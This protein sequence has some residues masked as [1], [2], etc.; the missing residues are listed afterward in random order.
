MIHD[1]TTDMEDPPQFGIL[2]SMRTADENSLEYAGEEVAS[3]QRDFYP[4]V[5]AL[6]TRLTQQTAF[7]NA[8]ETARKLG[9]EM[10]VE[11]ESSGIIEAYETSKIFGF[12]D[13]V[14]IRVKSTPEG[15]RVD[16][17]SVSRVGM[18]D[19][20]MNAARINKFCEMFLSKS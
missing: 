15:S 19:L 17:R 18:S 4:E 11:D 10:V 9:W 13:D 16:L 8:A 1:I 20:G 2:S 3:L 12:V 7:Q 6:Q 14:V 5:K